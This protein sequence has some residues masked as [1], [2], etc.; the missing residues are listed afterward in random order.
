MCSGLMLAQQHTWALRVPVIGMP[1]WSHE[2][3]ALIPLLGLLREGEAELYSSERPATDHRL[4][5]GFRE[6]GRR[7]A[8]TWQCLP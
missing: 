3:S 2:S 4:E 6:A 5:G 1:A 8:L 7:S